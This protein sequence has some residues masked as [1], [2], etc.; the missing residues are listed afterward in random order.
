MCRVAEEG[1]RPTLADIYLYCHHNRHCRKK[2]GALG[3]PENAEHMA[4][5]NRNVI[6][7]LLIALIPL[8]FFIIS[9]NK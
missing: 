4:S 6:I 8:I 3:I 9:M 2:A 1:E 7:S 5:D